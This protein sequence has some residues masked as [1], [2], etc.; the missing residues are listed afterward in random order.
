MLGL[1]KKPSNNG[2]HPTTP[3]I[4][5]RIKMMDLKALMK[6]EAGVR[7]G[8]GNNQYEGKCPFHDDPLRSPRLHVNLDPRGVWLWRCDGGHHGGSAIDFIKEAKGMGDGQAI[9]YLKKKL[10]REENEKNGGIRIGEILSVQRTA[11]SVQPRA[12][13]E[14]SCWRRGRRPILRWT[15]QR[16]RSSSGGCRP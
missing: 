8:W 4:I 7:L 3:D 2:N 1:L 16:S 9:E 5:Q 15:T 11:F 12:G 6:E 14:P 13:S 10:K